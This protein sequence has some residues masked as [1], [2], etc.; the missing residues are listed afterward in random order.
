MDEKSQNL[1]VEPDVY[2]G[3]LKSSL[4][5]RN[6]IRNKH[7]KG[8]EVTKEEANFVNDFEKYSKQVFEAIEEQENS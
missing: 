6:Q 1:T 8:L 3:M 4:I 7:E 5:L 2:E